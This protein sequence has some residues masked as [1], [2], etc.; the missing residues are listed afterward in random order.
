METTPHTK[1]T[2]GAEGCVCVEG[3]VHTECPQDTE[4]RGVAICQEL[5]ALGWGKNSCFS[6][7][8]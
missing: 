2:E 3:S 6:T 1:T 7:Y 4:K 5:G 8:P